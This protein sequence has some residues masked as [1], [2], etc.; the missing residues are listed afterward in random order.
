MAIIG[1]NNCEEGSE[2][3]ILFRERLNFVWTLQQPCGRVESEVYKCDKLVSVQ[4]VPLV[5]S[6][7]IFKLQTKCSIIM[8]ISTYYDNYKI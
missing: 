7:N 6:H 8:F 5:F 3:N 4:W 1:Q 2:T